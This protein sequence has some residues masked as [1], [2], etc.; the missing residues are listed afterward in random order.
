MYIVSLSCREGGN[1]LMGAQEEYRC[2]ANRAADVVFVSERYEVVSNRWAAHTRACAYTHRVPRSWSMIERR[3]WH[4]HADRE[5]VCVCVTQ[6]RMIQRNKEKGTE[7]T[8]S[9]GAAQQYWVIIPK[10]S[11]AAAAPKGGLI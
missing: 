1:G 11:G 8:Q 5:R 2:S 4:T 9:H 10:C 7:R 6:K 3:P